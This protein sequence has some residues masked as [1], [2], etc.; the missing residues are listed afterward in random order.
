MDSNSNENTGNKGVFPGSNSIANPIAINTPGTGNPAQ[1]QIV[2]LIEV[3][4]ADTKT[5]IRL[6]TKNSEGLLSGIIEIDLISFR[7]RGQESRYVKLL[8]VGAAEDGTQSETT[9]SIDNEVD[10]NRFKK[11]ISELNWND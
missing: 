11:F 8:S 4:P 9:I 2:N 5:Y 3:S 1:E 7:E 6:E 10:F